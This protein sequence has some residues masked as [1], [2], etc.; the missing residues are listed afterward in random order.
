[1]FVLCFDDLAFAGSDRVA[2]VAGI[3]NELG[4]FDDHFHVVIGVSGG[5]QNAIVLFDIG[6]SKRDRL[7]LKVVIAGLFG[8]GDIWIVIVDLGTFGLEQLDELERWRFADVIN[9]FFVCQAED[10][11]FGAIEALF[12]VV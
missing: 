10:E 5:Y 9:V 6:W 7:H 1:M 3:D 2:G 4:I 8:L 11:D 12:I